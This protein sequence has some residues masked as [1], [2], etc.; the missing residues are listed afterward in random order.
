MLVK[1]LPKRTGGTGAVRTVSLLGS[2]AKLNWSQTEEGLVVKLPAVKPC[3][4]AYTFEDRGQGTVT[5][6]RFC[7]NANVTVYNTA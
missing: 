1:S 7:T 6:P 4:F 2:K 3:D 5:Y